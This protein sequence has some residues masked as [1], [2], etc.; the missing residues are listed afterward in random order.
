MRPYLISIMLL[1]GGVPSFPDI[2]GTQVG[3]II[4]HFNS[5]SRGLGSVQS[6]HTLPV[7]LVYTGGQH[8]SR[9]ICV[10]TKEADVWRTT[11]F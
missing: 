10:Y 11:Y 7:K 6:S 1:H 9:P 8:C 3:C 5:E 4:A 2:V